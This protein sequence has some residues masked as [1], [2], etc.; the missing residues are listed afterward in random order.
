[1]ELREP[2]QVQVRK[3]GQFLSHQYM[4]IME[5]KPVLSRQGETTLISPNEYLAEAESGQAMC[6]V[7]QQQSKMEVQEAQS[8]DAFKDNPAYSV[9]RRFKDTVF[10]N[11]L[12]YD[13][14]RPNDFQHEIDLEDKT[15]FAV[16]QFRLSPEQQVAVSEWVD[17]MVEA[18][19][20]RESTSPYNSPIF[21]VK[22]PAGWRIVHDYRVLNSKTR[23]P[24]GPIPRK[25]EIMDVMQGAYW[26][27][28]LDL[29]SGYY[30]LGLRSSDCL[31]TAF[32]TPKGH[33]EYLVTAQ[34]LAGAPS[35]FN[36]FV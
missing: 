36:R 14:S 22:K 11:K 8:W 16:K 21:C 27:S 31:F 9:L 33:F 20:I 10:Q 34:G 2:K 25:D 18:G 17:E 32:S 7:V 26:F 35:T 3:E 6:F 29:L 4:H 28:C 30:Q 12:N 1:M 15:P 24:K 23:I 19:L 13:A 5:R